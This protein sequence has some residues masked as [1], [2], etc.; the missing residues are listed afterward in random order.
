MPFRMS[1]FIVRKWQFVLFLCSAILP[2]SAFAWIYPEHRDIAILAVET[3]D[4]EHKTTFDRLWQDA[5]FNK[6]NRL[7]EAGIDVDQGP[8]PECIDWVALP[9][10]AGDHSCSS[11]QMLDIVTESMWILAIADVAAESATGNPI[12]GHLGSGRNF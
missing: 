3:L 4:A 6:E 1:I 2:G 8:T 9:A 10:I 5:R 11:Q 12:S 7:C